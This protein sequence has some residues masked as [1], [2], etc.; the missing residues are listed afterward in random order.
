MSRIF[1]VLIFFQLSCG[2]QAQSV[3]QWSAKVNSV[4]SPETNDHP[5]AF[6]WIP[7]N[8]KQVKGVVFGQHN[9]IEEGMLEN[10]YF[11][12][13]LTELGFAEVWVTPVASWTYDISKNEDKAIDEIFKTLANTSGYQELAYVPIIPIGHSAMASFPW[14]YAAFNPERTLALVS[15]HGDTPQSNLTGSGKPNPDWGNKNID[16]IPSLFIMGEYEW[17]DARIQPA[18]KYIGK[19]PKSVITLFADAG[20]GHFDYSDQMV[21]YVADYIKKAAKERLPSKMPV[22]HYASLKKINPS[23]GWLMDKWRHDSIPEFAAAKYNKYQGDRKIASWVFDKQMA[24]ATEDFYTQARGKINQYIGF[25][26]NGEVLKPVNTHAVF[27]L[28]FKPLEDG[29]SFNLNAFFADTSR[30]KTTSNFVKM[31]IGIDRICGPVK[32]I[33]DSIFQISFDK[34]GFNNTKR[35]NNIWLLAH[36]DGDENYKSAV[37]QIDLHFPLINK[38]G[39]TQIINFNTINDVKLG[40]KTIKLNAKSDIGTKVHYY[41]KEGPAYI[42][43]D[44]LHFTK[45][46]PRTKFP[47]KV[48]VVAWQYGIAGK[49]QSA[50]H[51]ERSFNIVQ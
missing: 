34:L 37:Q 43:E 48:T 42:E 28:I 11:R 49:L 32:K 12:K 24:K 1:R 41:V 31:P 5:Q 15:V 8:C 23:S 14:N 26:Q 38:E 6:L 44:R 47:V 36:N 25:K 20:H 18:Y 10:S 17:W 29:I 46:P 3:W 39:K 2:I 4:I 40:L 45:I 9:M 16:G 13:V 22:D 7:E 27:Q 50:E 30:V 35:S 19:H 21:K 51:V 33:N